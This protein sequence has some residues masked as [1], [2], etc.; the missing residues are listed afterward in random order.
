VSETANMMPEQPENALPHSAGL[1]ELLKNNTDYAHA[2]AKVVQDVKN[3]SPGELRAAYSA[4]Y[5]SWANRKHCA[6]K[7]GVQWAASMTKFADFLLINGPIPEKTWT[8]DRIDPE[9]HYLPENIRW[10]SKSVQSQNRTNSI[11][12]EFSGKKY[13]LTEVGQILEKSYD[14]VRMG[15]NRGGDDYIAKLMQELA[16]AASNSEES[17]WQFPEEHRE[18]L[19]QLYSNRYNQ[20]QSRIRFFINLTRNDFD[21]S[22]R[23][24]ERSTDPTEKKHLEEQVALL[25]TLHNGAVTELRQILARKEMRLLEAKHQ[26]LYGHIKFPDPDPDDPSQSPAAYNDPY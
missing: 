19:E 20:C 11:L 23:D 26:A 1:E 17:L 16:V 7:H 12:I 3:L 14:A 8:L 24:A 15:I 21:E 13:S 4:E 10:A 2:Y 6:K 9:G 22:T 25:R 5:T 18:G